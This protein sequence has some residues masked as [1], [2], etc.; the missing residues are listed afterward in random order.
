MHSPLRADLPPLGTLPRCTSQPA[1]PPGGMPRHVA[2]PHALG[3][4]GLDSLHG[5]RI[6]HLADSRRYEVPRAA[7]CTSGAPAGALPNQELPPLRAPALLPSRGTSRLQTSPASR[8]G[9]VHVFYDTLGDLKSSGQLGGHTATR[10]LA[11]RIALAQLDAARREAQDEARGTTAQEVESLKRQVSRL[12]QVRRE[13]DSYIQDLLAD[14]ETTQRRQAPAGQK[15]GTEQADDRGRTHAAALAHQAL[16]HEHELGELRKTLRSECERNMSERISEYTAEYES[17]ILRLQIIAR[18]LQ[19]ELALH[20]DMLVASFPQTLDGDTKLLTFG[21]LWPHYEAQAAEPE[22]E[23]LDVIRPEEGKVTGTVA[24]GPDATSPNPLL[25]RTILRT[26]DSVERTLEAA[27]ADLERAAAAAHRAVLGSTQPVNVLEVARSSY[28]SRSDNEPLRI[29]KQMFAERQ[30]RAASKEC[31][32][33]VLLAW[34]CKTQSSCA[35]ALERKREAVHLEQAELRAFS[36][37][38]RLKQRVLSGI[39]LQIRYMQQLALR[40]WRALASIASR[41]VAHHAQ[42]DRLSSQFEL[43]RAHV[44]RQ[45]SYLRGRRR[46]QGLQLIQLHTERCLQEVF[47]EWARHS[48]ASRVHT[49]CQRQLDAVVARF[50][51]QTLEHKAQA[52]SQQAALRALCRSQGVARI[53]KGLAHLQQ[54]TLRAWAHLAASTLL[55]ALHYRHLA[56][57]ARA[58]GERLRGQVMVKIEVDLLHT[59]HAAFHIWSVLLESSKRE[60][61]H[62]QHCADQKAALTHRLRDRGHRIAR[63]RVYERLSCA[64]FWWAAMVRDARHQATQRHKALIS[65]ADASAE[66]YR[67]RNDFKRTALELRRQRRSHG[68]AAIHASLDRRLQVVV[69]AWSIVARDAQRESIYQRQLDIAAAESAAGCAV[70]RMEG[71]RTA[72][73][74]RHQRRTQ[75]LRAIRAGLRHWRHVVLY[76]WG[77]LVA[78]V[79]RESLLV[80]EISLATAQVEAERAETARQLELSAGNRHAHGALQ[81]RLRDLQW[82]TIV[83]FSWLRV[84]HPHAQTTSACS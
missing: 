1:P 67:L 60:V 30:L 28:S 80:Q 70:L 64:L 16:Q 45:V 32:S 78:E 55:E 77:A 54:V 26:V 74:L 25:D 4:L 40:A 38:S 75:A 3:D 29:C 18:A 83:F 5:A 58:Y 36:I 57:Q 81:G 34:R 39:S 59:T 68:V 62:K 51:K 33:V 13:R 65:A 6:S 44:A 46:T 17:T 8:R 19:Q 76:A 20:T 53:S 43:E 11:G 31:M 14:A 2:A 27:R 61:E 72:L 7:S 79:Q 9:D 41:K 47:L 82:V 21:Q 66:L 35:E 48:H 73:E 10:T 24:A 63:M 71:R 84:L 37:R 50:A 56:S 23:M 12:T 42:L 22:P 15:D 52:E 69:H 49:G